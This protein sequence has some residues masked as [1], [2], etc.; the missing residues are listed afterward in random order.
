[1]AIDLIAKIAPKNDGFT[2]M[3]DADQVI[4][5][6]AAG[7]LLAATFPTTDVMSQYLLRQPTADVV[8][9]E[10]GAD[11]N[12]RIEGDTDANLFNL[13]AGLD[14]VGIGTAT[15]TSKLSIEGARGGA[16]FGSELITNVDFT[17]N[18][19]GWTL[20]SGGGTPDWFYDTNKVTHADGG[21]IATLTPTT[22]LSLDAGKFYMITV[23]L[24]SVTAG[25]VVI[26]MASEESG[27]IYKQ[28]DY[29]V[30]VGGM[31]VNLEI[32]PSDD[33]VGSVNSV[34]VKEILT[35]LVPLQDFVGTGTLDASSEFRVAASDGMYIGLDAGKF[36]LGAPVGGGNLGIGRSA[37]RSNQSGGQNLAIGYGALRAN[38]DG[39]SNTA[40]GSRALNDNV[41]GSQNTA[42]GRNA[43]LFN[44]TGFNN[45]AVG[46]GSLI[47][48]GS[49]NNN[50]AV[51]RDAGTN[52]I[53]GFDLITGGNNTFI[54]YGATVGVAEST[55]VIDDAI[56][57]GSGALVYASDTINIGTSSQSTAVGLDAAPGATLHI[58]GTDG[59]IVPIGTTGE[60]VAT[61]GMVRFNTTTTKFEG[62]TG[63]AWVDFH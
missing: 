9:N 36:D 6:G 14:R 37:L 28:G 19:N 15:P 43:L 2:G 55:A 59:I 39:S 33:F 38:A 40:I 23:D 29:E 7:T 60:R 16:T 63:A 48:N 56:A 25:Y 62:Y 49:G 42:I 3:V 13:D 34:S 5:G 44:T 50:T 31:T 61:Q 45:T 20:G 24:D 35:E 4:G 32:T 53:V 12:F 58:G 10:S 57:I 30:K 41:N 17:G 54:G 47:W 27:R 52:D 26:S 11:Y 1:M 46:D 21:G 18:A 8:I 22:P 51:G